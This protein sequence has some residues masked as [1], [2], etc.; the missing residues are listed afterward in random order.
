MKS[1]YYVAKQ[2]RMEERNFGESSR[3]RTNRALWSRIWQANVPNKIKNFSWCACLNMPTQANLARRRVM[4]EAWNCSCQ[5]EIESVLHVLWGCGGGTRCLGWEFNSTSKVKYWAG[6]FSAVGYKFNAK[7]FRGGMGSVLG[8]LL[9]DLESA[10]YSHARGVFQH[11][12]RS[13]QRA[14]EYL[15]EFTEA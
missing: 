1:G 5:L 8:H 3:Q 6:R 13:S 9:A 7:T 15:R 12:S 10:Q 2:L 4:E 14:L 11:P